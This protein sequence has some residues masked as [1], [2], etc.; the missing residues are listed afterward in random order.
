MRKETQSFKLFKLFKGGRI[1]TLS[2]MA[3]SLKVDP[4]SVGS[5]VAELVRVY[6]AKIDHA[7]RT[8]EWRLTNTITVPPGGSAGR[9]AQSVQTKK[10]KRK[11]QRKGRSSSS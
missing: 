8:Q 3:K 7:P 5:Y 6:G 11:D 9:R 2:Q 4:G 10:P 1:V